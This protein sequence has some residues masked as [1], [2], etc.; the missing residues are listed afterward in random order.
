[1]MNINKLVLKGTGK[2]SLHERFTQLSKFQ[3]PAVKVGVSEGE[4]DSDYVRGSGAGGVTRAGVGRYGRGATRELSPEQQPHVTRVRP[5]SVPVARERSVD[6]PLYRPGP[7][8]AVAAAAKLKRRSI[9]QV[10][11]KRKHLSKT[12]FKP[13]SRIPMLKVRITSYHVIC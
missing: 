11:R 9:H 2:I 10:D 6:R 1:M 4:W 12:C 3:V 13:E 8:A 7:S 5:S